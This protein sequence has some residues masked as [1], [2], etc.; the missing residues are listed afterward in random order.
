M[1]KSA[2]S[3]LYSPIL[4]RSFAFLLFL[5]VLLPACRS[6][7]LPLPERTPEP[8][9]TVLRIGVED[10]AV[11][12]LALAHHPAF[13]LQPVA[14]NTETLFADLVAGNLDALL[15]HH[16]PEG[17]TVWFNPVAVD[18]LV[19][20]VHPDNPLEALTRTEVQAMFNGRITNWAEVGGPDLPILLVTREREASA[21]AIF[22]QR[23]ML[24][25]R[26][27]INAM[28][29]AADTA[30]QQQVATNPG[31]IGYTMMGAGQGANVLALDGI[32]PLPNIVSAQ[33]YP[34]SI[35][36]YFVSLAEPQGELRA[37]LSWLQSA[38]G[39]QAIGNVYGRVR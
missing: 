1:P 31:A 15:T 21:R 32:A 29:A 22:T 39:Q 2:I 8:T 20:I 7:P 4:T 37:W 38:E 35:P 36:L 10:T 13:A 6:A 11:S 34:I 5:L 28:V 33:A 14:A 27:S 19:I 9:P 25:Q 17:A 23:I 24:E 18:A 30:V 3:I 26:L 16:L 12:F